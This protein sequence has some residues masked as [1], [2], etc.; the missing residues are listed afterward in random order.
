MESGA[1]RSI[2]LV[3][4]SPNVLEWG[5]E[6]GD[7]V[8]SVKPGSRESYVDKVKFSFHLFLLWPI[9]SLLYP[10]RTQ[11]WNQSF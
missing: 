4:L 5:Q 1:L 8:K 10:L 9:V 11:I 3:T 2:L 6:S 7:G